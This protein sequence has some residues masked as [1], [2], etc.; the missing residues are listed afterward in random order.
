MLAKIDDFRPLLGRAGLDRRE[1]RRVEGLI[2]D[3]FNRE[4]FVPQEVYI[5]L[6]DRTGQGSELRMFAPPHPTIRHNDCWTRSHYYL[7]RFELPVGVKDYEFRLGNQTKSQQFTNIGKQSYFA[8]QPT[9]EN[10]AASKLE[11]MTYP[12]E[13]CVIS[14]LLGEGERLVQFLDFLASESEINRRNSAYSKLKLLKEG[15][16]MRDIDS[17]YDATPAGGKLLLCYCLSELS[18][19]V[20]G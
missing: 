16:E 12:E 14:L 7:L 4:V 13:L 10:E 6:K 5:L 18:Y 1:V 3:W 20:D 11:T 17:A 9:F 8:M 2:E 15:S 19:C